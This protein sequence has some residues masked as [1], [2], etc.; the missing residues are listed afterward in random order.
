[1]D[2]NNAVLEVNRISMAA[3]T[4]AANALQRSKVHSRPV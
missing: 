2:I 1:M 4:G 3:I